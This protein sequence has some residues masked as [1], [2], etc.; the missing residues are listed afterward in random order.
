MLEL[1]I[2]FEYVVQLGLSFPVGFALT[3]AFSLG[4]LT[5]ITHSVY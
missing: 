4:I 5:T 3:W 2:K 1:C